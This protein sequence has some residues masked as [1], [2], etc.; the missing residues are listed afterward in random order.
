M[1]VTMT[2]SNAS[3][4]DSTSSRKGPS[5]SALTA[6]GLIAGVACGILFGELCGFLSVVGQAF[7]DLLQMT[8]L[9]YVAVAL[10]NRIGGLA[11][12]DS[13]RIA[14]AGGAVLL[15]T[16]LLGTL[17]LLALPES[18]PDW[19][20]GSFY[21]TSLIEEPEPYSLL[22]QVIPSNPFHSLAN[23]IVPAVVL[24]CILLGL[25]MTGLPNKN[26]PLELLGVFEEALLKVNRGIVRLVPVG[27]F[28]IAASVAG[29]AQVD[30]FVRLQGYFLLHTLSA[31]M[32]VLWFLPGIVSACTPFSWR[33]IMA[34]SYGVVILALATGKVLVVIPMIIV[35][36]QQLVATRGF[37]SGES[38][39][40]IDAI[41]PL[42]YP[43]PHL[44]RLL[45]LM[46]VPFAA[47][48]VGRPLEP[49]E[50]PGFVATG[51][52]TV[53]GSP[54]IGIPY[55]LDMQ[56]LPA[57]LFQLFLASGVVCGR[58]SDGVGAMHLF[59]IALLTVCGLQGQIKLRAARLALFLAITVVVVA[60]SG[61]TLNRTMSAVLSRFD[62]ETDDL[63]RRHSLLAAGS[64][65]VHR[66][67]PESASAEIGGPSTLQRLRDGGVL[68]VGYHP[69]NRPFTF[70]NREDELVGLDADMAYLLAE[71]L[72]CRLEFVPFEFETLDEQL[73]RGDFDVAM[74]G[75]AITPTRLLR[76]S[77]SEPTFEATLAFLVRD[78]QR[79]RFADLETLAA[80]PD[81]RIGVARS[82]YFA[83]RLQRML[84]AAQIERIDSPLDFLTGSD[85]DAL[86]ISAE[87]GSAW[88]L[89]YPEFGVV[90][91][92]PA[93]VSQ[94]VGYAV[95]PGEVEF[96]EFLN[97][98]VALKRANGDFQR[99]YDH[100]ILGKDPEGARPRWCVVRDVLHWID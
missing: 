68:R 72:G 99:L 41:V 37:N 95:A 52:L 39:S 30:E 28:A 49:F 83:N 26:R 65:I 80:W 54:V 91:P 62:R 13:R 90:V 86:L 79:H 67:V 50:L 57:D 84:P 73:E 42:V 53:F 59:V 82:D 24:F 96:T 14:L 60:M 75:I 17:L 48:Y 56:R 1:A 2:S 63:A 20:V 5:A 22:A 100:W 93:T 34:S 40:T 9:P 38:R 10:V 47:W 11:V 87:A 43:F 81:V 7:V 23:G 21:S 66:D 58:L 27:V 89:E 55:L 19:A 85:L 6:W 44:G 15:I 98:W 25:A 36:A 69:D 3:D 64:A 16:S 97:Q 8:V 88:T 32:L 70:F 71:D 78:F 92:Q 31:A 45:S 12:R 35:A 61:I 76:M 29:T 33:E 18:L 94:P 46:F 4:T 77:F 74:S 51:A